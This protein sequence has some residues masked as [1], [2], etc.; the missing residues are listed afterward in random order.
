MFDILTFC[1]I[2]HIQNIWK[3]NCFQKRN[4]ISQASFVLAVAS[5]NLDFNA[6]MFSLKDV[7]ISPFFTLIIE[8]TIKIKT[9]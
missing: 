1:Q 5:Q 6:S 3:K 4:D 9:Y 8:K 7:R 2:I